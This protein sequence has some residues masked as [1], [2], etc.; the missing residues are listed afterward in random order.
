MAFNQTKMIYKLRQAINAKGHK[1]LFNSTEFYSE[2]QQRPIAIYHI[3]D[4]IYNPQSGKYESKELFS[5]P[6]H[7]Q[8]VFF[9]RDYLFALEGKKLPIDNEYWNEIRETRCM[10]YLPIT[11]EEDEE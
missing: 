11:V 4:S 9:L 5:S 2:A 7:L 8:I 10:K 3:K 6:S 1:L